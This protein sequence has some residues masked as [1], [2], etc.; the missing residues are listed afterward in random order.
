M[1]TARCFDRDRVHRAQLPLLLTRL[2]CTARLRAVAAA[3]A[4]AALAL[5]HAM[6]R[7]PPQPQ[8]PPLWRGAASEPVALLQPPPLR[9]AVVSSWSTARN[10]L[11]HLWLL[12]RVFEA[13]TGRSLAPVQPEWLPDWLQ[14]W[15]ADV[16]LFGPYGKA[17][18]L[19]AVAARLRARGTLTIF[20]ASEFEIGEANGVG[21]MMV[22]DVDI[23]L[24]HRRNIEAPNYFRMPF[25][26]PDVLDQNAAT[27]TLAVL[28]AL[29]RLGPSPESWRARG[30]FA[31]LLS[32]HRGFPRPQL[33][34]LL[35][36]EGGFVRA[37]G[38]AFHNCEWPEGL[39]TQGNT[40]NE[41]NG[42]VTYLS[43]VRFNICPENSQSPGGG[44]A[45]EKL[46]HS[47]LAGAVPIYWG[48]ASSA[49]AAFFNFQRVIVYNG[50]NNESVT[51]TV[52]RLERNAA[53]RAEW[54]SRPILQP[55]AQQWVDSW[56]KSA[57]RLVASAIEGK[58]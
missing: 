46:V 47:F 10:T 19:R 28:P 38:R 44:Y 39:P 34:E 51:M 54:F 36:R 33:F 12:S 53:F 55:S 56:A 50:S 25:W 22:H 23:S 8:Q 13:A 43:D 57:S 16:V 41:G 2:C 7:A 30:G 4:I 27:D 52:R 26:L 6:L 20:F 37:P 42:K 11:A 1:R 14:L 29:L 21:D 15:L 18:A 24:G 48:D 32:S 45:T 9:V 58:R 40:P 17:D 35:T 31:A 49:D 5:A 3:L